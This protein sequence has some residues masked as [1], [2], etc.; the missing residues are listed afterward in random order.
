MRLKN[1][2]ETISTEENQNIRIEHNR[3]T[4]YDFKYLESIGYCEA[5]HNEFAY[6]F[7]NYEVSKIWFNEKINTFILVL[8]GKQLEEEV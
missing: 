4:V 7:R 6:S 5:H 3:M 2:L 1:L 8:S